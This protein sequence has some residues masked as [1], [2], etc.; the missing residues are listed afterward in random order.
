MRK[1]SRRTG[2][3]SSLGNPS[4][5][6]GPRP[7]IGL[8]DFVILIMIFVLGLIA[9][10]VSERVWPVFTN[11]F[12]FI[13]ACINPSRTLSGIDKIKRVISGRFFKPAATF[14][15]L[16]VLAARFEQ[17]LQ[18]LREYRPGGWRPRIRI[19]GREHIDRALDCGHG[20]ILWIAPFSSELLVVKKALWGA[21][22]AIS[23]LSR[24]SHGFSQTRFGLRFLNP[25][26]IKIENRYVAERFVIP[27][28]GELGWLRKLEVRLREN[29]VVSI[30]CN[31]E[32]LR[33]F[34]VP[35][36]GGVIELAVGAISLA[37]VCEA[38]LLPVFTIRRGP[39]DFDVIIEQ[40]LIPD[41]EKSRQERTDKILR[42]YVALLESYIINYP[43]LWNNTGWTIL[44]TQPT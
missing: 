25:I 30:N 9:W 35:L 17:H 44:K 29:R 43:T 13:S 40:P 1:T 23:H 41:H 34:Q 4:E 37:L 3:E 21:G 11:I 27:A 8:R 33:V 12:G 31:N 19:I 20:G 24:Y 7:L 15:E 16:H 22:Y 2:E 18:Y 26:W 14:I 32:G 38:H 5:I 6:P 42:Q 36:L 39:R 10:I 28:S